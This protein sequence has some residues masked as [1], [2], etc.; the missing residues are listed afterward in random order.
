MPGSHR[1][2]SLRRPPLWAA[3][4]AALLLHA[5]LVAYRPAGTSS[6]ANLPVTVMT[7]RTLSATPDEPSLAA[8]QERSVPAEP[9]ETAPPPAPTTT[10]PAADAAKQPG[11][12]AASARSGAALASSPAKVDAADATAGTSRSSAPA[13]AGTSTTSTAAATPAAPPV[14][15]SRTAAPAPAAEVQLPDAPDY[16]FAARLD[17]G[18][19]PLGD[20]EP[21][22]PDAANLQEGTVVIR[23]LIGADGNVD[24]VA[25]VRA[26]PKG[27][28][29]QAA[30]DAFGRARF[31]PG[32]LLGTPV[33]SQI[34][35]EVHF[36]PINR[37][38]RVSGRTY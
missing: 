20:I 8:L 30:L 17:P 11:T 38:A 34:T 7:V 4:A 12:D 26:Q 1:A 25:V 14:V 27:L 35:V 23:L 10:P 2:P 16:L 37:G 22:Y 36:Q 18:P 5:T 29:E 21:V 32:Y 19:R 33:K 24:N 9:A 13:G 31:A 15:A 28:F 3:V 6:D